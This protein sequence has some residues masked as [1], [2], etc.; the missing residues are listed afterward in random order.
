MIK[1][2]S[3]NLKD[4]IRYCLAV[5]RPHLALPR[6]RQNGA[7][8]HPLWARASR[9]FVAHKWCGVHG[10]TTDP[11]EQCVFV[12]PLENH[13]VPQQPCQVIDSRPGNLNTRAV[14]ACT[15]R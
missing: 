7:E 12:S 15:S 8:S 14:R 3:E 11:E 13:Q 1:D 4:V 10:A 2:A 6:V 9:P 5:D